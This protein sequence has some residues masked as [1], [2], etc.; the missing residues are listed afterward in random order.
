MLPAEVVDYC[1]DLLGR[2]GFD[3]VATMHWDASPEE[4]EAIGCSWAL[5]STWPEDDWQAELRSRIDA[6]PPS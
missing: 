1:G 3:V 5:D 6:G 2:D 4:Y